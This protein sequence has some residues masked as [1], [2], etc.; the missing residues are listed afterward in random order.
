MVGEAMG[1]FISE[2]YGE[3]DDVNYFSKSIAGAEVNVATGLARLGFDI[4]YITKLGID[5]FGKYIMNHL[6]KENINTQY[7]I[8]DA[9]NMTGLQIKNKVINDDPKVTYYRKNSSFSTMSKEDVEKIDFLGVK[10]FH[11]T[12]IPLALNQS[13]RK[14][15]FYLIKKAKEAGCKITFDPNIRQ[16]LWENKK[17]M[18][19]VINEVATYS[20]IFMPGVEEALILTEKKSIEDMVD[21]YLKKGVKVVVIKDG[22]NGAYFQEKGGSLKKIKGFKVNEV[23]DTVGAG[24]GFAA[25]VISGILD[26]VPIRE[27]IK[28]GNAIGSIQVQDKSDNEGLPTKEELNNY[29]SKEF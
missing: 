17:T 19:K 1:L 21:F 12:G 28:R 11:I 4:G 24:D 16:T 25:G 9:L 5:P 15:M 2:D 10:V 27:S 23:I 7:V 18:I 22:S 13:T 6:S 3:F 14:M 20:D 29:M 26:E 8:H